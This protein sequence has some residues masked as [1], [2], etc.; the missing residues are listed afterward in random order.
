MQPLVIHPYRTVL[1]SREAAEAIEQFGDDLAKLNRA[2]DNACAR[3]HWTDVDRVNEID[4]Q[5]KLDGI[6]EAFRALG[7]R[8]SRDC[9][10][11]EEA[12]DRR[13]DNPLEPDYRRLGV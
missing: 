12:E 3:M 4:S 1:S 6:A 2:F 8:L 10:A 13:R 11:A 9:D 5:D 7:D